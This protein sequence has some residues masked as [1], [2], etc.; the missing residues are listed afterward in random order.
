MKAAIRVASVLS[1]CMAVLLILSG[2]LLPVW[3]LE[4]PRTEVFPVI[5]LLACCWSALSLVGKQVDLNGVLV[6]LALV[7]ALGIWLSLVQGVM[8]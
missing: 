3:R 5:F 8:W 2:V 1:A 7:A 6:R 4:L